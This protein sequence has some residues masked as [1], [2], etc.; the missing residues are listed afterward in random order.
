MI[1]ND[2]KSFAFSL[3]GKGPL[4]CLDLGCKKVG[5]AFSDYDQ[6]I[7]LPSSVYFR[8][9]MKK[10]LFY[11]KNLF[12]NHNCEG[13]V[14][15]VISDTGDFWYQKILSFAFKLSNVYR[16][17]IYLQN[18][19]FSTQEAIDI[20]SNLN[21]TKANKHEDKISSSLILQRAIMAKGEKVL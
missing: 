18:E 8:R 10:D 14:M 17:N 21:Y 5:I 15:G 11:I 20:L 2:I 3:A 19:D 9:N 16:I 4:M 12:T 1:H 6:K 7:A 13:L